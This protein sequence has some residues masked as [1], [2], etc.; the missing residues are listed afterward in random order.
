MGEASCSAAA[1][2]SLPVGSSGSVPEVWLPCHRSAV[3]GQHLMPV[4]SQRGHLTARV[5]KW[6]WEQTTCSF[7]EHMLA[8]T[9]G[10][11]S[12]HVSVSLNSLWYLIN[13]ILREE[14][15]FSHFNLLLTCSVTGSEMPSSYHVTLQTQPGTKGLPTV[16]VHTQTSACSTLLRPSLKCEL[17]HR[18]SNAIAPAHTHLAPYCILVLL[19]ATWS[20][21]TDCIPR[22]K[23]L[24]RS[25]F[26]SLLARERFLPITT[27]GHAHLSNPTRVKTAS[28]TAHQ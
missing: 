26:F 4:P 9:L 10:S 12:I 11:C 3:S 24:L 19:F 28:A 17:R 13:F 14:T 18:A 27:A 21:V 15:I 20:S 16:Y 23:R 1:S 22:L 5:K 2:S 25:A 8:T 7:Q 6:P